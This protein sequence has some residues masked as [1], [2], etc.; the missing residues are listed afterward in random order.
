MAN[1]TIN[2]FEIPVT[3]LDRA[4]GFYTKVM[5]ATLVP[6]EMPEG[7]MRAFQNG[8]TPVGALVQNPH[9][10]PSSNGSM[11]YF[12]AAG[13]MDAVLTKVGEAGGQVVMP[14]TSIG[15]YGHIAQF[16]DT[17]GNRIALHSM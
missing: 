10:S 6:M 4:V 17:E 2:W 3:N 8:D 9:N 5:G 14:K 12:D 13:D 15:A 7:K 1:T 11:I 16:I